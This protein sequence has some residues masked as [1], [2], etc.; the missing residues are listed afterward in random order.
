MGLGPLAAE[1]HLSCQWNPTCETEFNLQCME[2]SKKH[3]QITG[4]YT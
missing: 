4:L 3:F 1:M 2:A